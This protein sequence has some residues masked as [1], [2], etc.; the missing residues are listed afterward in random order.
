MTFPNASDIPPWI[1]GPFASSTSRRDDSPA[2]I[3]SSI[4]LS[5]TAGTLSSVALTVRRTICLEKDQ[6]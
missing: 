2:A 5:N 6:G 1:G 4:S 3:L